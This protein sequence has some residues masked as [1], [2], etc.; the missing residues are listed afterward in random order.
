M[1]EKRK[2]SLFKKSDELFEKNL[3]ELYDIEKMLNEEG[4]CDGE[5]RYKVFVA[6][7]L[8]FIDLSLHEIARALFVL[9]GFVIGK[10]LTGL[11]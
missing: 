4:K 10:F 11:L 6:T 7:L 9:L 1:R 5:R 8:L 2:F 3:H